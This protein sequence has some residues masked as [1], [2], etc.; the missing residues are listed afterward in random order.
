MR[1]RYLGLSEPQQKLSFT[2]IVVKYFPWTRVLNS[3]LTNYD[4]RK[5]IW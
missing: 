1:T 3:K 5:S 2:G 4:K